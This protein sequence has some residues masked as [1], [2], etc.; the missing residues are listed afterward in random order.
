MNT[1]AR[2]GFQ[3][4]LEDLFAGADGF[5]ITDDLVR[6]ILNLAGPAASQWFTNPVPELKELMLTY[7]GGPH[8][9]LINDLC[10]LFVQK[11]SPEF[12]S[13]PDLAMLPILL[14]YCGCTP[15]CT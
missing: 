13:K 15:A 10:N 6:K 9:L 12:L 1:M 11:W 8:A 7:Q 4:K 5:V 14:S 2:A 3:S